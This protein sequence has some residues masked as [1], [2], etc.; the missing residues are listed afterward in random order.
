V[1]TFSYLLLALSATLGPL[2]GTRVFPQWLTAGIKTVGHRVLSGLR[3][4]SG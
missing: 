1:G 3:R 4:R 2:I